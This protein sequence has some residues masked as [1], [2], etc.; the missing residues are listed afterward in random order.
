MDQDG[1]PVDG[2]GLTSFM[3]EIPESG[4]RRVIYRLGA[5]KDLVRRQVSRLVF[6]KSIQ[7]HLVNGHLRLIG[8]VAIVTQKVNE[9]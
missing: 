2:I 5:E 1:I 6:G 3:V 9:R 7:S 4:P 8:G